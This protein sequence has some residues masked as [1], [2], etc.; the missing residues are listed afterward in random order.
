MVS[1][2][3]KNSRKFR[4]LDWVR[5]DFFLFTTF[6]R[7]K[8]NE[9]RLKHKKGIGYFEGCDKNIIQLDQG[10]TFMLQSRQ[11][12]NHKKEEEK[13]TDKAEHALWWYSVPTSKYMVISAV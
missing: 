8:V 10:Q 4:E 7:W 3:N 2:L 13:C 11:I 9:P 12:T 5:I 1:V 6:P